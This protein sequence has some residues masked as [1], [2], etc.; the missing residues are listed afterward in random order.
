[1]QANLSSVRARRAAIARQLNDLQA[2]DAELSAVE[3][4][5]VRLSGGRA[6]AVAAWPKQTARKAGRRTSARRG[7]AAAKGGKGRGRRAEAG[8]QRELVLGALKKPGAGWMNIQ[9]II[10]SVKTAH[11]IS[12][13]PRSLSPLLSNLKKSGAIV[14]QGRRVAAPGG[15]RGR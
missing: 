8:S 4:V 9:Q 11:G 1:M 15:G 6:S 3:G 13:P 14:R 12:I 10:A 2:E 5:L 7:A